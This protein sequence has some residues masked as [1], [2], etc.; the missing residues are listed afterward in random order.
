[1]KI[2]RPI[3]KTGRA[4]SGMHR[5]G[6]RSGTAQG[7]RMSTAMKA[8]RAGTS[9]VMTAKGRMARLGTASLVQQGEAFIDVERIVVKSIV[10][11]R[12]V[13]KPLFDYIFYVERNYKKAL[14]LASEA[15][16]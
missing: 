12:V 15:V 11:K 5:T 8:S 14:E 3:S 4:T 16:K 9:R 6:S 7:Q 13:S 2:M 10:E 1:M